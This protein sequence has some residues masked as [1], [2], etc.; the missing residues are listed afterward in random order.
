MGYSAGLLKHR[1]LI[2][3]RKEAQQGKFGLDADGIEWEGVATVWADVSF[4]KGKSS[5][6]AGAIDAYG[7][8]MVRMRW[9][10][11]VNER[12]RIRYAGVTYQ[13]LPETFNA[14]KQ[15]N[16]IQFL[17]QQVVNE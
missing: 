8:K 3:N 4:A 16:Q 14:E 12:S 13:I 9:N 10:C 2:M 1:V 11:H 5:L 17:C 6:N 7:V 15:D